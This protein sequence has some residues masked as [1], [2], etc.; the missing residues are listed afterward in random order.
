VWREDLEG[1]PL[2]PLQTIFILPGRA[3]G[4]VQSEQLSSGASRYKLLT[5]GQEAIEGVVDLSREDPETL[6]NLIDAMYGLKT[7]INSADSLTI[8]QLYGLAHR[9]AVDSVVDLLDESALSEFIAGSFEVEESDLWTVV[10]IA[11][12]DITDVQNE[13]RQSVVRA[14]A[15][16]MTDSGYGNLVVNMKGVSQSQGAFIV[17]VMKEAARRRYRLNP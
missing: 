3:R 10:K 15:V 4:Q 11:Y 17:D 9:L 1:P 5:F 12:E 16:N 6:G 14:T 7:T 13:L 8:A 2:R